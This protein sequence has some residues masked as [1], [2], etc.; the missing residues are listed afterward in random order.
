VIKR[1]IFL[2]KTGERT[3]FSIECI[4]EKSIINHSH[5]KDKENEI[6]LMP[7][8]YFEVISQANPDPQLHTIQLKENPPPISKSTIWYIEIIVFFLFR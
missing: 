7:G 3:I 5:Y 8:S 2:G 4:S 6:I 1:T